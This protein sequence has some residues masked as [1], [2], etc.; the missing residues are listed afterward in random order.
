MWRKSQLN[1]PE[2]IDVTSSAWKVSEKNYDKIKI[3]IW[4]NGKKH[5]YIVCRTYSVGTMG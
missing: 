3:K 5:V 1:E 4:I 2:K